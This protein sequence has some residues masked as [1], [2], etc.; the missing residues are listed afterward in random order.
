MAS[1]KAAQ[2]GGKDTTTKVKKKLRQKKIKKVEDTLPEEPASR[3]KSP[4]TEIVFHPG[5]E[6]RRSAY[7]KSLGRGKV[8]RRP[9]KAA[10]AAS[11]STDARGSAE[12]AL[13]E[14]VSAAAGSAPDAVVELGKT[15]EVLQTGATH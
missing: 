11:A 4:S 14:P 10:T 15:S 5:D 1:G 8:G 3:P 9:K 6:P 12:I 13:A 7:P 2:Q